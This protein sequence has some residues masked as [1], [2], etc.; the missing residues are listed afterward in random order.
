MNIKE[1]SNVKSS[2]EQFTVL[3]TNDWRLEVNSAGDFSLKKIKTAKQEKMQD[4][5]V[6]LKKS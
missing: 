1:Q 5:L 6:F 4:D 3:M 2:Y